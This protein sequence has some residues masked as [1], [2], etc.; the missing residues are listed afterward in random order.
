MDPSERKPLYQWFL[1]RGFPE[2]GFGTG[3]YGRY[4]QINFQN[5]RIVLRS[6]FKQYQKNQKFIFDFHE[7]ISGK[8]FWFVTDFQ[9][10][11]SP[12]MGVFKEMFFAAVES[13]SSKSKWTNIYL[14]S[15]MEGM[16]LKEYLNIDFEK[17]FTFMLHPWNF[18]SV[19]MYYVSLSD[20]RSQCA[21]LNAS[22]LVD[23]DQIFFCDE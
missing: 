2:D 23:V 17:G 5:G 7:V 15:H 16:S 19:V 9:Y 20:G 10:R 8:R 12:T 22:V 1:D 11:I 3:N 13:F 6:S 21:T 18:G 14:L 4:V